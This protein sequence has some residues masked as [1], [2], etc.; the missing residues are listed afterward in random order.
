MGK[1]VKSAAAKPRGV[2]KLSRKALAELVLQRPSSGE[3][4]KSLRADLQRLRKHL[5]QPVPHFGK[6]GVVQLAAAS[7][8]RAGDKVV[9]PKFNKYA[10]WVEWQN[11]IFLWVNAT[12]GSFDN[13]FQLGGRQVNWYVGGARPTDESPI[14]RR[15]L[16]K[17]SLAKGGNNV[18][19]FVR[20]RATSPYVYCGQCS[21]MAHNADKKGFEFTWRL[22]DFSALRSSTAFKELLGAQQKPPSGRSVAAAAAA[23]R[24]AA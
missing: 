17:P 6:R 4:T 3:S 23:Q 24:W 1:A 22:R 19:L 5:G 20:P 14:V 16:G 12:G 10:G 15:L 13:T 11:A 21:Y 18:L 2:T 9:A 7:T 8:K